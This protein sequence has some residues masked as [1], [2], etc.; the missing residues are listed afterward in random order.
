MLT[1]LGDDGISLV[2]DCL[3]ATAIKNF[4]DA[5][6]SHAH[7][8]RRI[9]LLALIPGYMMQRARILGFANGPPFQFASWFE[10]FLWIESRRKEAWMPVAAGVSLS[11]FVAEDGELMSCGMGGRNLNTLGHEFNPPPN[12]PVS[13][14]LIYDAPHIRID[15]YHPI[16][17]ETGDKQIGY[18]TTHGVIVTEPTKL[19]C[20]EGVYIRNVSHG[21]MRKSSGFV[22]GISVAV[23]VTG[24]VY[25]WGNNAFCVLGR[26]TEE[27]EDGNEDDEDDENDE[28]DEYEEDEE[29]EW[30][31]DALGDVYRW[32]DV[33][34]EDEAYLPKRV[35]S[36]TMPVLS[37]ATGGFHCIAVTENGEVF[38]WGWNKEGQCGHKESVVV[39]R[40]MRVEY[41]H[42][43]GNAIRARSASAGQRHSLIVTEAGSLYSF[44]MDAYGQ[45]GRG[46]TTIADVFPTIVE[47]LSGIRLIAVA[48][49]TDHSLALTTEGE[50]YAWGRNTEGQLGTG[51]EHGEFADTPCRVDIWINGMQVDV[52]SLAAGASISCAVTTNGQLLTWGMG[53][54]L[55]QGDH[56]GNQRMQDSPKHVNVPCISPG[57]QC[58]TGERVVAVSITEEHILVVTG[59]HGREDARALRVFGWGG[60]VESI[61]FAR[62]A[63]HGQQWSPSVRDDEVGIDMV[64]YTQFSHGPIHRSKVRTRTSDGWSI[65]E[66]VT[67]TGKL[68]L[69]AQPT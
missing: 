17:D 3:S 55:G 61:C 46:E 22:H 10:Y 50:V 15:D 54:E 59:S 14:Q 47:A 68:S 45:L 8:S 52:K 35:Q 66:A 57:I 34:G 18:T 30:D 51:D 62:S 37:V 16:Y 43:S 29:D 27:V 12:E 60:E 19:S 58:I 9:Q 25:T 65:H 36:L 21:G 53:P 31:E 5:Y 24:H 63:V 41:K 23:S 6:M 44:G 48:T 38:S 26:T 40:P 13:E 2:F 56:R 64:K 49:G 32:G 67:E 7:A 4:V 33:T 39:R 11:V 20:M 42:G 28:D 69:L 1:T